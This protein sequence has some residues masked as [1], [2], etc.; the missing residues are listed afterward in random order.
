MGPALAHRWA[1]RTALGPQD[2]VTG[3]RD[4][5]G[6]RVRGLTSAGGRAEV[7]LSRSQRAST[8]A[9]R[10]PSLLEELRLSGRPAAKD[11]ALE[12]G[13][14]TCRGDRRWLGRLTQVAEESGDAFGIV[15]Q[16][17]DA[18]P[19]ATAVAR[20]QVDGESPVKERQERA[21]RAAMGRPR[22]RRTWALERRLLVLSRRRFGLRRRRRHNRSTPGG[23]SGQHPSITNGV[24]AWR[25]HGGGES[26]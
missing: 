8:D 6:E 3:G 15:D 5:R 26:R 1:A 25:R 21:I 22:W 4:S 7:R 14:C 24:L 17:D 11:A 16:R 18:G 20:L 10:C 23:G 12:V 9:G 19:P 2:M 13:R